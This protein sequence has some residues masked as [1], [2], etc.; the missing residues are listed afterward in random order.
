VQPVFTMLEKLPTRTSLE[1]ITFVKCAI[2]QA[3]SVFVA[4]IVI[5]G[6]TR[7]DV[8]EL[9]DVSKFVD[10]IFDLPWGSNLPSL[11]NCNW[12]FDADEKLKITMPSG[13][14]FTELATQKDVYPRLFGEQQCLAYTSHLFGEGISQFLTSQL[15]ADVVLINTIDLICPNWWVNLFVVSK[16]KYYQRDLNILF[17]GVDFH[18]Y[19]RYQVLMKFMFLALVMPPVE[20]PRVLYFWAAVCFFQCFYIERYCFVKRYRHQ[21]L[22]DMSFMHVLI[23]KC[24]PTGLILHMS[25]SILLFC[26]SYAREPGKKT[27]LE[28]TPNAATLV[29]FLIFY[30]LIIGFLCCWYSPLKIWGSFE[31]GDHFSRGTDLKRIIA[32]DPVLSKDIDMEHLNLQY[33]KLSYT[34][35]LHATRDHHLGRVNLLNGVSIIE[36]HKYVPFPKRREFGV[37]FQLRG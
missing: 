28:M 36:V 30:L 32:A 16:T 23:Y 19:L 20:F 3:G 11:T 7:K 13:R 4:A 14:G 9:S 34:E 10:K 25:S 2:F 17:E 1:M 24:L 35:A 6:L 37:A 31:E 12:R 5:F 21:P 8:E 29:P 15:A 22:Y 18:P 27:G 26:F 33:D